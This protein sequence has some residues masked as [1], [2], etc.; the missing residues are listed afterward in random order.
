LSGLGQFRGRIAVLG[1]VIVIVLGAGSWIA[2]SASSSSPGRAAAPAGARGGAKTRVSA[3]GAA[4]LTV[5]STTPADHT[6]QVDGADPVTVQF[7]GRLADGSPMPVIRPAIPGS[8]KRLPGSDA[9][10]FMPATGFPQNAFVQV[11]IPGGASGVKGAGGRL[12]AASQTLFFHVGGY[13]A[14]R[15]PQLLAELGYL[16]LNWAATSG[17]PAPAL[18]DAAA[19]L[20]A[21][22]SPPD[23]TFTWQP[24][25]PTELT[26]F[27]DNGSPDGL[28]M[29]G[30][31]MAFESDHDMTMD[32]QAGPAVWAALL[33]AA[34][35]GEVNQHGYT[36]ALASQV[37][38]ETLTVW[39][40][41]QVILHT[42]ANTGIPAAPTTVGT[43]PVYLRYQSQIMR[44][45][46][47]DGSTYADQ[48]YWV[49]YFRAG[50]AV[51]YFSRASYGFQ[52]S[53]GCVELPYNQA[54]FVW[55]YMT[56]GTLVTVTP[57]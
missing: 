35:K 2:V 23:G 18:G 37:Q 50:E 1:V 20:A 17:Q 5:A 13:S 10:E 11:T 55:P 16:P 49:S 52:Q 3:A 41:G 29:H 21:A 25:Y 33:S 15:L 12:L 19:Q 57:A 27:W 34:D 47:P 31:I 54:K 42:L 56:Y 26:T 30:A 44:G 53:L 8:W 7:S 48:V 9:I 14:E 22:Y 38:P 51:H 46:N 4:A 40:N 24:G 28:I 36:Y 45:T 6:Q 39:H 32:G 43:A